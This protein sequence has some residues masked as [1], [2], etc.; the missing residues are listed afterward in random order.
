MPDLDLTLDI[1]DR[2]PQPYAYGD[3]AIGDIVTFGTD[4]TQYVIT[5]ATPQGFAFKPK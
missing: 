4:P 3:V 5:E 1:A 2:N